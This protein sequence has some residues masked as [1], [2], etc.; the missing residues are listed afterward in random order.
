[1]ASFI[2]L[3]LPLAADD[4]FLESFQVGRLGH[5]GTHLDIPRDRTLSPERF[6]SR[7]RVADVSS[8][9][10]RMIEPADL[11]GPDHPPP[12]NPGEFLL[13]HTGW[14]A[15]MYGQPAY[16]E[17]HPELSDAAVEYL[18]SLK[19]NLIG[20]DAP[21]PGRPH[22]HTR[23]DQRLADHDIFVVE[24]VTG[25]EALLHRQFSVYCFPM[26]LQGF[27]GLP[28]RLLAGLD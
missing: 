7:G 14:L 16:F 21:G 13:I 22:R 17:E 9:R 26:P 5:L 8:V 6:I 18:I 20:I 4:R 1:M 24:N 15:R 28:V 12:V 10:E 25:T 23:L 3:S 19:P 27:S 11:S 2:D